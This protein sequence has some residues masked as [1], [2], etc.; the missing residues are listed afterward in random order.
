MNQYD[1]ALKYG[2]YNAKA[3]DDSDD[4]E[5]WDDDDEDWDDDD[6]GDEEE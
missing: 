2:L 4:D 5:D 3:E 6:E 1:L